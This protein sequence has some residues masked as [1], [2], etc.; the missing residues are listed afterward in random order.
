LYREEALT[1]QVDSH[2]RFLRGWDVALAKMMEALPS[3]KPLIT[4]F[5]P[6]YYI[7]E[8][9]RERLTDVGDLSRVPT[10]RVKSWSE[11]GWID[12]P[13]EYIAENSSFP[14]RTRVLSGA[15]VFTL[16]KWNH[17]VNQ[18]PGHLYT[19]EELALTLRSF[20]HGYDLFNPSHIV[21]WHRCHP[22][23]NRKYI[24]DFETAT[25]RARHEQAMKRLQALLS[26]DPDN[27]LGVFGLGRARSLEQY[28]LF[29]GL[30]C[31]NRTIHPDVVKG[32]PPDPVTIPGPQAD[33]DGN[34]QG[35]RLLDVAIHLEGADPVLV[36]CER[37]APVLAELYA[38]VEANARRSGSDRRDRLIR[39]NFGREHHELYFL[40][41]RLIYIETGEAH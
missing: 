16:G 38:A 30:D 7:E 32:T 41:S 20:T 39:L 11:E 14:R 5:P 4:G 2:T 12:H 21:V 34:E 23:P 36:R 10:T 35:S 13:T 19:G 25:V 18:D 24:N 31:R 29:S 3:P 15:F 8:D 37:N 1:L 22:R 17:E 28:R 26:G 6:L 33:A 9:G 27:E 40:E